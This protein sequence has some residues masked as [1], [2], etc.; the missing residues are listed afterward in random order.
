MCMLS[1]AP[2]VIQ[3]QCTNNTQYYFDEGC[4][5]PTGEIKLGQAQVDVWNSILRVE[6]PDDR[7][8]WAI[9]LAFDHSL[10]H[11]LMGKDFIS[12]NE[13]LATTI[14]ES[15]VGCDQNVNSL[16]KNAYCSMV[17]VAGG[18]F[19]EEKTT[20]WAEMS[21]TMPC[22]FGTLLYEDQVWG[23]NFETSSLVKV[24]HDVQNMMILQ[25]FKCHDILGFIDESADPYAAEKLVACY[26]NRGYNW[27]IGDKIFG[28]DR[29]IAVNNPELLDHLKSPYSDSNT[30]LKNSLGGV[31][32]EQISRFTKTLDDNIGAINLAYADDGLITNAN[33]AATHKFLGFYDE[34][35]AWS[36]IQIFI[37]EVADF[38][39]PLGVDMNSV[40]AKVKKKFDGLTG[41]SNTLSFRY[42]M[43]EIIDEL[44]MSLPAFDFMPGL[45]RKYSNS[46]NCDAPPTA[47]I[48]A[49][50]TAACPGDPVQ[51]QVE[52]T[53]NGPFTFEWAKNND[54]TTVKNVS[55]PY[56]F[57]ANGPGKYYVTYVEDQKSQSNIHCRPELKAEIAEGNC[58]CK[59]PSKA[60]IISENPITFCTEE[61]VC[62]LSNLEE[63]YEYTWF[64]DGNPIQGF[65]GIMEGSV[66]KTKLPFGS[67]TIKI[68]IAD[69]ANPTDPNCYL[70]D[71]I[72]V[73][74]GI[75]TSA[76]TNTVS[77]A[78]ND[79]VISINIITGMPDYEYK[80]E[81]I[82][83]FS[84]QNT[85]NNLSEGEYSIITQD[86]SSCRDTL[87]VTLE[88]TPGCID[89]CISPTA[90]ISSN[91]T[92]FCPGDSAEIQIS[93]TGAGP[94]SVLWNNGVLNQ[95]INDITDSVYNIFINQKGSYSIDSVYDSNSCPEIGDGTSII[96][97]EHVP[98]KPHLGKDLFVCTDSFPVIVDAGLNFT[99]YK[100]SIDGQFNSTFT[101]DIGGEFWVNTTDQNGCMSSDTI[102]VTELLIE[103]P[104]LGTDFLICDGTSATLSTTEKYASYLWLPSNA[105]TNDLIITT[106]DIYVLSVTND[107]GCVA[108]DTI[109]VIVGDL[110]LD[111]G[112]NQTICFG[113]SI[114]LSVLNEFDTYEWDNF[115]STSNK[116]STLSSVEGTHSIKL[117][118]SNSLGCSAT[119]SVQ[120]T[121]LQPIEV[122]LENDS[123]FIC[124]GTLA[125]LTPIIT[126]GD[127]NYTY[128]WNDNSTNLNLKATDEGAYK[129]V[130]TDG[131]GCENSD[132]VYVKINSNLVV[133]LA[134]TSICAG[135]EIQLNTG[136][137]ETDY[138]TIW[139][140]GS[141]SQ[142]IKVSVS[143]IYGVQ[144]TTSNGCTGS[145]SMELM[146]NQ[147]PNIDLGA[148]Q[149]VCFGDSSILISNQDFKI[150]NWSTSENT[151]SIT[152][153]KG[154][155]ILEVR[156]ENNCKNS[157]TINIFDLAPLEIDILQ[158]LS[159]CINND[160]NLDA[161]T[162]DNGNGPF[163]YSWFDG[164]SASSTTLMNLQA[165]IDIW[166]EIK[167]T[168]GCSGKDSAKIS[169][170][171]S[172][173]VVIS[174]SK[175]GEICIDE[176]E[177]LYSNYS[178]TNGYS[179]NWIG[180][181]EIS[182][183]LSRSW[184]DAG[185]YNF[186]LQVTDPSGCSGIGEID[187]KVSDLPNLSQIPDSASFC[188]GN[189]VRIGKDLGAAYSYLWNP[190][191]STQPEIEINKGGIY[192]LLV[193]NKNTNCLSNASIFV[194][195]IERPQVNLGKDQ[196]FCDGDSSLL[197]NQNNIIIGE[198][199][200][201]AE[202]LGP[203]SSIPQ[204]WVSKTDQY[205][206]QVTTGKNCFDSDTVN[207]I[208]KDKPKVDLG[209]DLEICEGENVILQ[210]QPNGEDVIWSNNST[211]V[212]L[213]VSD[214]GMYWVNL[215]N[216][217]CSSSDSIN[218]TV[219]SYPQINFEYEALSNKICF[220]EIRGLNIKA[221][222][223]SDFQYSWSPGGETTSEIFIE[224]G[225]T[226]IV[227]IRNQMCETSDSI[228][229]IDHCEH[230]FYV[231]NTFT[232]NNDL[233]N[234]SFKAKGTYIGYFSME[235]FNRWGELIF[236]SS[237]I[238]TGWNGT[239]N[240]VNVQEDVYVWRI[241]YQPATTGNNAKKTLMGH[242]SVI[243]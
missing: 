56:T 111:L 35:I 139:N 238:N 36:D 92:S 73:Q 71:E 109:E 114:L 77:C 142:K 183:T 37:D 133:R 42:E 78:G 162:F 22:V 206:L 26:Y 179:I 101:T 228:T 43:G 122:D 147:L 1:C 118:A 99:D 243:R 100:W 21:A 129:I 140:T 119:D 41:C 2:H 89:P 214:S 187:I 136:Y 66:L 210:V 220:D 20:G 31:Y 39:E 28:V 239:V 199:V 81:G 11:N 125:N 195:E 219:H 55:S 82:G 102:S 46:Y 123:I 65:S 155:Y 144:V 10:F 74:I 44:V 200:W 240:G 167:D 166:V 181:G 208:V 169:I 54:F 72:Q 14:Q 108:L 143:G 242:V 85:F 204:I 112:D 27:F 32:A 47:T 177:K 67:H 70:E 192:S 94:W 30:S 29:N 215:S 57:T 3:A 191:A 233:I 131:N 145:D 128:L 50:T 51:L 17:G 23:D 188:T 6:I 149:E 103:K 161:S 93:F 232:P 120:I 196:E 152:K 212:A 173:D 197:I 225:D 194:N 83:D 98:Q 221:N 105:T 76:D 88:K 75:K 148:D 107:S 222:S 40:T 159:T 110:S 12:I 217:I 198:F 175:K 18:F 16:P 216:G 124:T 127:G 59:P 4:F 97:E 84:D 117:K 141:T 150:Y 209:N 224:N 172:L 68:R 49:L 227:T 223:N 13:Y 184:A 193:K 156:D 48:T 164:S 53:G 58:G 180:T 211:A 157:D 165:D 201:S 121:V 189:I 24:Y 153:P 61:E 190:F 7:K 116:L 90:K 203:L 178:T 218:I 34:Q 151:K 33:I 146:I 95:T 15:N 106:A 96:I 64:M 207:I 91:N 202:K 86:A 126:G 205:I 79:G 171:D 25:N 38:Y 45:N 168:K 60:E 241:Q 213:S 130:V 8:E 186:Q 69:P 62:L 154:I 160:V 134:D 230:S 176:I 235:I 132:S 234:D 138:I 170:S 5:H 104:N 237:D 182:D 163:Q 135:E 115:T 63:G 52:F 113:D 229:F 87:Q 19:Q 231:P 80:I 9:A 236:Q 185:T 158:D 226:Y 174:A 137:N